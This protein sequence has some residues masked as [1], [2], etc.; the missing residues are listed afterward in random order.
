MN[1]AILNEKDFRNKVFGGWLGKNIGGTLGTPMEGRKELLNLSFYPVLPDKPLEND[2]L[3]LQ[4]VWL[5]ALEQYG[6]RLTSKELGQELVEHMFNPSDEYGFAVSNLRRGI[7]APVSGWFNNPFS[8]CMGSPIRSEIWAM[9]APGAPGVAAYYAYQDAI[10]DH[11]GGEGVY[12]EIFFAAIESAAFLEQDRDTLIALGLS[13]IPPDCRT[14]T[15]VKGVMDCCNAGM[16]WIEARDWV[17]QHYGHH[18]FTDAPQNIA[19]TILGWLYGKNFED[20]ILKAVN[21]GYDTDCTAATLGSILGIIQGAD[22]LP[23]KW[24]KPIGHSVVVSP[25]VKGFPAPSDLEELTDRTLAIAR[26]VILYWNIPVVIDPLLATQVQTNL[27]RVPGY[28]ENDYNPRELLQ[29]NVQ[30]TTHLLP[31]GTA[32][33]LGL[34]LI[35]NC[36]ADGPSIAPG[37]D[38]AISFRLTN[39]SKERWEGRIVLRVPVEWEPVPDVPFELEPDETLQ[40]ESL[41]HAGKQVQ[42]V[43]ELAL[44]IHRFHDDSLWNTHSVPISLIAASCWTIWGPEEAPMAVSFPGNRLLFEERLGQGEGGDYGART[45][46][47]NPRKRTV[48]LIVDAASPVQAFLD[49]KL[50]FNESQQTESMPAFHRSPTG[51]LAELILDEGIYELEIRLNKGAEPLEVYVLPVSPYETKTPGP[52]YYFTDMLFNWQ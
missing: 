14:A 20:A 31:E 29:A 32:A 33:K 21:C 41:V 19:F 8:D 16:T 7:H 6:A 5:H 15:A 23:E 36:G 1:R 39:Q 2:D 51:K 30:E 3:D 42:A 46:L 35:I 13:Y 18:N 4:L 47:Y 24:V 26:E 25:M 28:W 12:G 11:A 38:K 45:R 34:E 10:V 22:C 27:I 49:G 9:V 40:W 43:N 52:C 37:M 50:L 48:R 17:L 44:Q